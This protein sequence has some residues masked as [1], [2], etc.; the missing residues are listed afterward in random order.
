MHNDL[1]FA[2]DNCRPRILV[3]L[4]HRARGHVPRTL[5]AP[6]GAIA[7]RLC[8][9]TKAVLSSPIFEIRAGSKL[10]W[11]Y[12]QVRRMALLTQVDGDIAIRLSFSNIRPAAELTKE[13]TLR[14]ECAIK[15]LAELALKIGREEAHTLR[16]G[17][18]LLIPN[19][20][21]LHGREP[22]EGADYDRMLLRAYVVPEAIVATHNNTMIPLSS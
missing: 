10:R 17:E 7:E 11:R 16:E 9:D 4:A 12:E 15:D 20:Y 2:S 19:D 22:F 1:T 8:T 18:A 6:A 14:A 3:L 13:D 5:L 21:C